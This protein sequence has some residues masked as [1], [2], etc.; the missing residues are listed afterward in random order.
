[1]F[2]S[3]SKIVP[4]KYFQQKPHQ[5]IERQ[6]YQD[7]AAEGNVLRFVQLLQFSPNSWGAPAQGGGL[8]SPPPYPPHPPT[9]FT[10][11]YIARC[12]LGEPAAG[13]RE[14]SR[15]FSRDPAVSRRA[16]RR[17]FGS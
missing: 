7:R 17:V 16:P 9:N 15:C 14:L 6:G 12:S 11:D 1:M 10:V 3:F 8:P 2:F 4:N 5:S 13:Q